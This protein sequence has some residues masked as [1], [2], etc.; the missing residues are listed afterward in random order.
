M[1]AEF[2]VGNKLVLH[3]ENHTEWYAASCFN[4]VV[5]KSLDGKEVS[6]VIEVN[7]YIDPEVRRRAKERH[8]EDYEKLYP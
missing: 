3:P 6:F 2:N 1:K 4:D 7:P 5:N 8:G